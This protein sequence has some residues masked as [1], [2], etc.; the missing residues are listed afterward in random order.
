M[1]SFVFAF[2]LLAGVISQSN[3]QNNLQSY[4]QIPDSLRWRGNSVKYIIPDKNYTYWEFGVTEWDTTKPVRVV[5]SN[6]HRPENLIIKSPPIALTDGGLPGGFVTYYI[7]YVLNG[8]VRFVDSIDQLVTFIGRIDNVQE[9]IL[10]TILKENLDIDNKKIGGAYRIIPDGYDLML[11]KYN[12]CP[13]IKQA[14]Q[15]IVRPAGV[16]KKIPHRVYFYS[17]NCPVI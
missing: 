11:M 16:V 1:K 7:A 9:A 3:A 2:F 13:E 10:L 6:G 12:Q 14:I 5:F 17:K 8:K 15:V 4:R